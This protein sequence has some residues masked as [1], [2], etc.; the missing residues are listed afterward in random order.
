MR[1]NKPL[2]NMTKAA[3]HSTTSLRLGSLL[4][5]VAMA[6]HDHSEMS[7]SSQSSEEKPLAHDELSD[8]KTLAHHQCRRRAARSVRLRALGGIAIAIVLLYLSARK[9]SSRCLLL[10]LPC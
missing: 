3:A 8:A 5:T 1:A 2:I 7:M 10:S 9:A 4:L 6:S